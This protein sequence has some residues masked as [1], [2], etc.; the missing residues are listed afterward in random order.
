M[1]QRYQGTQISVKD[2]KVP[3]SEVQQFIQSEQFDRLVKDSVTR[4]AL[5]DLFENEALFRAL[6][7]QGVAEAAAKP[8]VVE[9]LTKGSLH[10]A[11]KVAGV[12]ALLAEPMF[13]DN[14][15][16]YGWPTRLQRGR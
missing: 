8:G 2:I 12:A 1:A 15:A 14:V 5:R 9:A 6:T 7:Q 11:L 10:E 3:D 13:A 4:N 16:R